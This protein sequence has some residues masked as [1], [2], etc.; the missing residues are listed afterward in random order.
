MDEKEPKTQAAEGNSGAP[1]KVKAAE[2]YCPV[3][4]RDAGDAALFRF[5]EYFCS[6]AHVAEF[7]GEVRARE[8]APAE[9]ARGVTPVS[10][11]A[12]APKKGGTWSLLKMGACCGGALLLLALIPLVAGGGGALAAVGSSV[13]TLAALLACPLGMY[14]M[15]RGMRRMDHRKEEPGPGRP[16]GGGKTREPGDDAGR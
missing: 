4:G 16:G 6:E 14:F 8:G 12:G 11:T 7:A 1:A 15:M 3:C 9:A 10:A 13:L 2:H 5:A